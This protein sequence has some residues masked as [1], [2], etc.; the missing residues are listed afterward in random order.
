M[1][2]NN[3]NKLIAEIQT[4]YDNAKRK[5]RYAANS[6][7]SS[8]CSKWDEVVSIYEWILWRIKYYTELDKE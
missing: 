2:N 6:G 3:V 4:A 7:T 8:D 5:A 1:E